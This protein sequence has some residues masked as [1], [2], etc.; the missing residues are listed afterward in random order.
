ML[1]SRFES[2]TAPEVAVLFSGGRDSTLA[3]WLLHRR[4]HRVRLLSYDSGFGYA[5]A[6]R[7]YRVQELHARLPEGAFSYQELSAAGLIRHICFERLADDIRE[8]GVQMILLGCAVALFASGVA[9]CADHGLGA[10][11][12]GAV[13]YQ[14]HFADQMPSVLDRFA[15]YA[16]ERGV[17]ALFPVRDIESER[18]V[19]EHLMAAGLSPKSLEASTLLSDLGEPDVP[20]AERFVARKLELAA[21]FIERYDGRS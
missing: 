19:R 5:S 10:V 20:T 11:A 16:D 2:A 12:T 3:A 4:G 9:Y 6:L 14:R 17:E 1:G 7:Q 21:A 15:G 18:S 13:G 8:D